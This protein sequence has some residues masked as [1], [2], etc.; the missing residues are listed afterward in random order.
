MKQEIEAF[1]DHLTVERNFSENTIAA[2]KN[3]L[4]QLAEFLQEKGERQ[5]SQVDRQLIL[6]YLLNL[7]E[8]GY[9]L[10]TLA[11]KTASA[12]SLFKFLAHKRVV[13]DAPTENLG[14]PRVKKTLP[15][16]LSV[17]QVRELL[18]QPEKYP[19]PEAK[20]DK[21]MLELLYS[22]GMQV[23]EL[24]SLNLE[25]VALQEDSVACS[26]KGSKERNIAVHRG[27]VP[28]LQKYLEEARPRLARHKEEKALFLNR[29]GK[30]LTRQ[31][32]WQI[33]KSY[34]REAKLDSMVTLR[35]LR[36]SFAAHSP[37]P[38]G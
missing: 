25:D 26:I 6:N 24:M 38:R 34:A 31:G 20:R 22:T 12:K 5:W 23:S 32:F 13:K 35:A 9:A 21:A 16:P 30:R 15:R 11:R 29:L 28:S 2:Y 19:T 14:S 10:T 36:H 7:K 18:K 8:R 1:L 27:S 17:A 3:D 4:F 37:S 33:L